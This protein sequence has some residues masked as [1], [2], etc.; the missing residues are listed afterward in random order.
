MVINMRNRKIAVLAAIGA[1]VVLMVCGT[2]AV[3]TVWAAERITLTNETSGTALQA[4]ADTEIME[5]YKNACYG[6]TGCT[7]VL[8][9]GY[10]ASE[11]IQGM[12]LAE[13]HPM[14][15]SNIYYTVEENMDTDA[16]AEA[17]LS[18]DYKEQMQTQF[19]EA[20][21]AEAVISAYKMI[22]TEV[23]GCP[24]YRVELSCQAGDMQMDQLIYV[25]TA[26]KVYTIT[27]SQAADDERME[28]FEKS[29]ETIRVVFA[30]QQ[31]R[32]EL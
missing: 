29:A 28:D 30:Q 7:L 9:T 25:I 2:F 20:Y 4:M 6:D 18:E 15:S 14:D 3:K 27:Y 13:R 26:D 10:I 1:A 23:S 11:N 31:N 22:Q 21:G 5:V 19:K 12:Y 8:P 17:M 16:L 24:A 32:K